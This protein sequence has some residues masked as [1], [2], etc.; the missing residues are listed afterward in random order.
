M[1]QGEGEKMKNKRCGLDNFENTEIIKVNLIL[2]KIPVILI[3]LE[4][5]EKNFDTFCKE[6]GYRC[7]NCFSGQGECEK[8]KRFKEWVK[9]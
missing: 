9:E 5:L 7:S 8:F 4:A 1:W 2:N 3:N 6:E